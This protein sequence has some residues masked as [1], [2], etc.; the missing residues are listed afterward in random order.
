MIF[1]GC[2]TFLDMLTICWIFADRE[3][4]VMV[5]RCKFLI[6]I[7]NVDE[8]SDGIGISAMVQGF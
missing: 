3:S 7:Q 4:T 8:S 2:D 6:D 5:Y 1:V